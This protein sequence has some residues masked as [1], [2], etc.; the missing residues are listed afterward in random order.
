MLVFS[1]YYPP[2]IGGLESHAD[3]FNKYLSRQE[4]DITVFTPRLPVDAPERETRYNNVKIIRF[5]AFEIIRNYPVPKFWSPKFWYMWQELFRSDIDMV[6]SRTRF[7]LTSFMALVYA[8][9]RRKKWAHIEHGSDFVQLSSTFKTSLARIYDHT[10]GRLIFRFSDKNISISKAVQT[11]VKK[12][13][14]RES[15]IVY[16]GLE[17]QKIDEIVP[18]ASIRARHPNK[19]LLTFVG[20]LYKWKGVAD[21][22]MAIRSLSGETKSKIVFL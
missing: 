19:I 7:F 22:V 6:V 17:M 4:V 20:R 21:S 12:F 9:I 8:K 11:F 3:E 15:P 14:R 5:P 18:N 2:H 13:D 1:P 16:R 10:F